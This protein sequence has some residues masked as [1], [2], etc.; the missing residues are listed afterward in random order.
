MGLKVRAEGLE[1][2]T[3][4]LKGY[5][6]AI[7]L[8]SHRKEILTWP[9]INVNADFS[10]KPALELDMRDWLIRW[11]RVGVLAF[12]AGFARQAGGLSGCFLAGCRIKKK[13]ELLECLGVIFAPSAD[14]ADPGRKIRYADQLLAHPSKVSHGGLMH[15]AHAALA[16]WNLGGGIQGSFQNSP[17]QFFII[18]S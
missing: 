5:C 16:A 12:A 3:N 10:R 11:G 7:E 9:P 18:A 17:L 15:L 2:S 14:I 4:S 1:P 6:S 13:G 8:R